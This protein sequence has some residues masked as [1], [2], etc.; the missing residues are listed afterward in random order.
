MQMLNLTLR[1][2]IIFC[3]AT[4]VAFSSAYTQT[5]TKRAD[6]HYQR[7]RTY[8][9]A[10]KNEDAIRSYSKAI[11]I[12]E[13]IKSGVS[14]KKLA[15]YFERRAIC[16]LREKNYGAGALDYHRVCSLDDR[17]QTPI[18]FYAPEM[19]ATIDITEGQKILGVHV[20]SDTLIGYSFG[21]LEMSSVDFGTLIPIYRHDT[22][23]PWRI[24]Y[25]SKKESIPMKS[26]S[27][28]KYLR[29][30]KL[31]LPKYDTLPSDSDV[32]R[33]S[34]Q[35]YLMNPLKDSLISGAKDRAWK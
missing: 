2:L 20:V 5:A 24:L 29:G 30:K 9:R 1:F 10:N 17:L 16:Y 32:F 11:E 13:P 3:I 26:V 25:I 22:K 8:E 21:D 27:L 19:Q 34:L 4:L 14:D 12:A 23:P 15:L 33:Y 28:S 31:V 35:C 18:Q 6:E 7:G